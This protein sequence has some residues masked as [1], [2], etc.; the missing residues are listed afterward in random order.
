MLDQL[1]AGDA[2]FRRLF[3]LAGIDPMFVTYEE[4][5]RDPRTVIEA[6]AGALGIALDEASLARALGLSQP[7]T[8]TRTPAVQDFKREFRARAFGQIE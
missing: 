2:G 8:P 6:I 3:A 4:I 7:Y 1:V 5:V